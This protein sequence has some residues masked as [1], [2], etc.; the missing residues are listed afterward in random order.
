MKQ[1]IV[2]MQ[3]EAAE[4]EPTLVWRKDGRTVTLDTRFKQSIRT[5]GSRVII[6][7]SVDSVT[8]A[9]NG[10]YECELTNS[11]GSTKAQFVI[12]VA[13]EENELPKLVSKPSDVSEEEGS[14]LSMR[15]N[16]RGSTAP[17]VKILRRGVDVTL[18]SRALV[19]VDHQNKSIS[20]TIRSLKP[21]DG[22]TYTVQLSS[23][24]QQCDSATFNVTVQEQMQNTGA[25]DATPELLTTPRPGSRRPSDQG[26]GT[27]P[28]PSLLDPKLLEQQLQAR[29]DSA[30]SRRTS[31]AEAIPGFPMLKHREAPKVEKEKFLDDLKDVKAKE[32]QPKATLKCTFVKA[33]ARFR[34]YKNKLEI[35]QGPKYNFLQEGN[36]YILEIKNIAMEDAAKYACKCNDITTVAQLYVEERKYN[37][38][39]N[40]KLPK[41]AEVVRGKDLTLECSVSDPRAPVS[42]YHKGN[43]L[44]Y[45]AGKIELK[46]RE[47]RCILKIC[48]AKPEAEGEYCCMVEGDETFVDVAVE[49]PDWFFNRELKQQNALETDPVATFECEVSDRDAEPIVAG[50]KYEIV[51]ESRLKR[52]LRIKNIVMD[53]DAT[54]TCKVAKKTTSARLVVKPDVEFKQNLI[55]TNGIET[56][57]KELVCRAYNPKK[58]PVKWY[59]DGVEINF[60]DRIS[61]K[62]AEGSLFLIIKSLE[63]E[64]EGVY[65]CRI[66]NHQTKG[67]LGVTECEKPPSVDL[68]NFDDYLKL[69][70]GANFAS[71]IP[72]KAPPAR[73][74][75]V[76]KSSFLFSGFPVPN[77][78]I[79]RNG[80]PLPENV[81][82]KAVIR[83]GMV[84]MNLDNA[85]RADAG[86]YTL[87]L[88]NAMGEVEV[89]FKIDVY[90]RPKPPKAP[91]DVCELCATKCTLMWDPPED[92]GGRPITHYEVEVMDVTAGEDW[93][94]LKSVKECK[95]DVPLKEGNKYK[96]RVRAVNDQGPSDYLETEKETLARDICDPPDPPGNLQ[97]TD[98][99]EKHVDLKWVK[100]RKE[101]GAPVKNYIV[102]GRKHPEGSW[103]TMKETSETKASVPWKE[104]ET[105]EFR[106]MAVNKAG[107]SEP[108]TATAPM[109]AKPRLLKPWIDKSRI[110]VTKLKVGQTFELNLRYRAEPD[111]EVKWFAGEK[112]LESDTEYQLIF[113][114]R[115]TS[116]KVTNAQ[117]KHTQLYKLVVSNEVGS[118]EATLEVVVLGKPSR[119]CGPLEV[120]DIT[121]NSCV[122]KWKPPSDDGGEPIHQGASEPLEADMEIIA[123]NPYDEPEAPG[124]PEIVDHDK[125]RIDLRWEP[126]ASDGGAPIIGYHVERKEP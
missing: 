99:D 30:S 19:K 113:N 102:E 120:T 77:M 103:L 5:E 56:K 74:D 105:Y 108:C 111:P 60:N 78:T 14:T 69:K 24:G 22:G 48:R 86:N 122:L 61:T 87:K 72:F 26:R 9:D 89:P 96:F 16:Y 28:K 17:T 35:F 13:K 75:E 88:A 73:R 124:K 104:G 29:R 47:N 57:S 31:L 39:F 121:K 115:D 7:L 20:L 119:P 67:R 93:K 62:E 80:E 37:Y 21:E 79:L 92:D 71:A 100:P 49:D 91:L 63:M 117:R 110:Q 6:T 114:H 43:K 25:N 107:K 38:Y 12:K 10:T 83:N 4:Q 94:P 3:V 84:N 106:V 53:D 54:Y 118:D 42:W 50:D 52:I 109:L 36:E 95:C 44:E 70:K 66:G 59:K 68:A 8:E 126:P 46:R 64:D 97:V 51:S 33:N 18:D 58:Y 123:K 85:Q 32:G 82:L 81:N 76:I 11:Y 116:V 45:V 34:W 23:R 125:D 98:Y 1:A 15:M 41:T 2:E 90:D 65:S 101:N 55:D 40:Q 112:L 27:S